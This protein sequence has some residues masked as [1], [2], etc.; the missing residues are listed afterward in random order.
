MRTRSLPLI[1]ALAAAVAG[2]PL[3]TAQNV[4]PEVRKIL[5]AEK[6]DP[7]IMKGLD[8]ELG[9]P[10]S[11]VE[12]AK[13][14]G[15][16]RIRLQMSDREFEGMRKAFN[17][18]YPGIEIE[19]T[20]GIGRERAIAPLVG[21][22]AGNHVTD[23]VSAYESA[24][25]D[26]READALERLTGL[27]GYANLWDEMKTEEG[28]D[29]ADK[30][31]YWCLGYSTERVKKSELPK[32]WDD[33]VTNPRWRGKIGVYNVSESWLPPLN[34]AFGD[35]WTGEWLHKLTFDQKAQFRK[36]T[37]AA[38][39]KLISV[40]EF[41][42]FT[43]VMDYIVDRDARKGVPI[44]AHCVEPIPITAGFV[45]MFRGSP[46]GNAAKLF[47]NWYVSKEG[48]VAAFH[49]AR[50]IPIHR[51]LQLKEFRPYPEETMGKKTKYRTAEI[52][53]TAPRVA[54]VFRKTWEAAGT[55]AN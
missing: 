46:R 2:A 11:L 42:I 53:A 31:N 30:L 44:G 55:K 35:K 49:H 18:R 28:T 40:G 43:A 9:V 27:P 51:E 23:I 5:A 13:K 37:L 15:K 36:E 24:I 34:A 41:D 22:K 48:Q 6:L 7:A 21:F 12:A 47:I 26:Y 20:R 8:K 54:E 4:T 33:L 50:A 25:T 19:Y 17:A 10:A 38:T 45:G 52:L 3:A 14:E 39:S 1:V 16:L 32:T 29:V